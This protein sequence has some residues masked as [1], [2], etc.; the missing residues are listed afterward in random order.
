MSRRHHRQSDV[1]I[2]VASTQRQDGNDVPATVSRRVGRH[3]S[4]LLSRHVQSHADT[5]VR[6]HVRRRQR[7][8]P[9]H[10]LVRVAV[11]AHGAHDDRVV[12]GSCDRHAIPDHLLEDCDRS[13]VAGR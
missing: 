12:D 9:G 3:A 7:R 5:D 10:E 2:R 1:A 4:S 11:R 6:T 13:V 8:V